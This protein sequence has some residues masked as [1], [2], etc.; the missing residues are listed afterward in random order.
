[1]QPITDWAALW[2]ELVGLND[3]W[4]EVGETQEDHWRNKAR[5]FSENIEKR[6]SRSDSSRNF[7]TSKLQEAPGST[8]IDIGAGTGAWACLASRYAASITAVDHSRSMIAMMRE[9][10]KK[11][12]ITNVH[13][14]QGSWPD[15]DVEI[16]DFSLCS[17]AVYG[18]SYFPRFINKMMDVTRQTCFLVIRAPKVDGLMAEFARMILGHPYDSPNFVIAYNILIEM[19]IYANVLVEDT[20]LW[21]G[22]ENNSIEDALAD[23]KGRLG[24]RNDPTYDVIFS[25]RLQDELVYAEGKYIW[26]QGV[27][28]VLIYWDC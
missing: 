5:L 23:V 14:L 28:S 2:K 18:V 4:Q 1:M 6:W 15:V 17:H 24:L 10:L 25:R 11:A 19:G 3:R 16:H 8:L 7:L 22:W 26:P 9:N 27:Q 21:N 20:G 13:I 12:E